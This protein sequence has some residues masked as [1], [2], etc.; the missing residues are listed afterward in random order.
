MPAPAPRAKPTRIW[1]IR[2][3]G[4]GTA[5]QT[6]VRDAFYQLTGTNHTDLWLQ[7]GDN[8][9][10]SGTDGE[11]QAKVF[12]VYSSLLRTSV[13]WP[14][15]G[16]HDTAQSSV[17]TNT[18]PYFAMFTLPP[19]GEAGGE[20]SSTESY[21]SFDYANIHFICL[22]SMTA[23]RSPT[24]AM[25]IWLELD[26]QANTNQW[27]IAYWHHPPYSKGSHD[28]DV[29]LELVEMRQNMLPIL[30]AYG[31]DLVLSGHSHAY[32]RSFLLNG[33]YGV[34]TTLSNTMI[35]NSGNGR[36]HQT[37]WLRHRESGSGLCGR[38]QLWP[39][40][41]RTAQSSRDVCLGQRARF[42]VAQ[43]QQQPSRRGVSAGDRRDQR[44]LHDC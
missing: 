8:A 25:A 5:G 29:E 10:N 32:E 9:Y 3:A 16:N 21:Y 31:V 43:R 22:N 38:G 27:I 26:L 42:D 24:G 36:L 23:N 12:D 20:P 35:L 41:W 15:L 39:D 44:S 37:A 14:T 28:S 13:T 1:V 30:E 6:A 2:D 18:Y 40:Q 17:D 33:H 34:S 11:Y 4:T 19:A 7:L